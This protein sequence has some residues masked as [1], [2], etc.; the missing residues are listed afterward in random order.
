MRTVLQAAPGASRSVGRALLLAL[1]L[2]C[3]AL[4]APAALAAPASPAA[5]PAAS[6]EAAAPPG[7]EPTD[8]R[9]GVTVNEPGAAA[10]APTGP[11]P[12][13][14]DSPRTHGQELKLRPLPSGFITRDAGWIHFAYEPS[15]GE[16]VAPLIASAEGIKRELSALLGQP[17]LKKVTVYVARTPGEMASFAPEGAPFPS[18]AAGVAYSDL[19]LV[20]LTL[21]P[22]HPNA[23]G[24]LQETFKHE[25]A[26]VALRDAVAGYDIPRWFNEGF[27]VNVSGEGR[28]TRLETLWRAAVADRLLPLEKLEH[29]FPEADAEVSIAYAQSADVL[30]FLQRGDDSRRFTQLIE[31]VRGGEPF[32]SALVDAYATTLEALEHEWR[33]DVARRYSFWPVLF[34]GS[35]LWVGAIAIAAVGWHRRRKQQKRTLERW[36]REE[37][38]EDARRAQRAVELREGLTR[39]HIVLARAEEEPELPT[40]VLPP[41]DPDVPK[42][43]VDGS[44]HTLH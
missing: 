15:E 9:A 24:T 13:P 42:V 39:M 3:G 5:A 7:P 29:G 10:P 19:G 25:L 4:G 36:G 32:A 14:A 33:E 40:A 35:T 37:D 2:V 27:A 28:L 30:R 23:V 16:R 1:L 18:Y 6:L 11:R 8:A 41:A 12:A 38:A 43:R 20:L 26:H 21:Q 17:V 44:W 22:V 31:R 34:G